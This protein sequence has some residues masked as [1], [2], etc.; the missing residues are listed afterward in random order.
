MVRYGTVPIG[1]HDVV[2]PHDV[3]SVL[4][5]TTILATHFYPASSQEETTT[6]HSTRTRTA[7]LDGAVNESITLIIVL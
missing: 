7:R 3:L 1:T 6:K 5:E 2:V 4:L